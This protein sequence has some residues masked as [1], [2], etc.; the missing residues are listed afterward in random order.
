MGILLAAIALIVLSVGLLSTTYTLLRLI[1]W[2]LRRT[3]LN[4]PR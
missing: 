4:G 1:L 2:A 3:D